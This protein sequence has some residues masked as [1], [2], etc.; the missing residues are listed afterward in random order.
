MGLF[1][2]QFA[3]VMAGLTLLA[4]AAH[5]L[6]VEGEIPPDFPE[7]SFALIVRQIEAQELVEAGEFDRAMDEFVVVWDLGAPDKVPSLV[8]VR[9]S[10][11]RVAMTDFADAHAAARV[12][13]AALRDDAEERLG[14][15]AESRELLRD[16]ITLNAV[17]RDDA[18]LITWVEGA[19]RD[20]GHDAMIDFHSPVF[21]E[22][23]VRNERWRLLGDLHVDPVAA[24]NE[25]A[26]ALGSTLQAQR[27][28]GP[29][30]S[31]EHAD[32][33][34]D[35]IAALYAGLL[36]AE[37]EEDAAEVVALAK[38]TDPGG[39]MVVALVEFAV[40]AGEARREHLHWLRVASNQGEDCAELLRRVE[41]AVEER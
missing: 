23:L 11:W 26:M 19:V 5:A 31:E 12:R 21:E 16:W 30:F 40:R 14:D 15:G 34:R 9:H 4:S 37:R 10:F 36:A 33:Y 1:L 24:A 13:F 25:H 39:A 38:R 20:G 7:A 17:V 6:Q 29:A 32:L 2:R 27:R 18:R 41:R 22:L 28:G 35:S 3:L 8:A